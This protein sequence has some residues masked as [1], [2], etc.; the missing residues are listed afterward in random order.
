MERIAPPTN[1]P[2]VPTRT[3]RVPLFRA[4]ARGLRC[5]CPRCGE[6]QLY[7]GFAKE[8]ERCG[9]C[10]LEYD[11]YS[12][13]VLGFLYMSTAFL[14]GLFVIVMLLWRPSSVWVGRLVIVPAALA[15]Y[16]VTIPF[17]KGAALGVKV[18]LE[19]WTG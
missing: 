4:V 1:L 6:G 15:A 5:R 7:A 16:I 8:L 13:E 14:T 19:E 10:K 12:G 3:P 2:G 17:R 9:V 11:W 18:A